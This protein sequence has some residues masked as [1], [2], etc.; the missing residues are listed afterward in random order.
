MASNNEEQLKIIKEQERLERYLNELDMYYIN[1]LRALKVL[2]EVEWSSRRLFVFNVQK[3]TYIRLY[4]HMKMKYSN[5]PTF[6]KINS[7]LVSNLRKSKVDNKDIDE[8]IKLLENDHVSL[9]DELNDNHDKNTNICRKMTNMIITTETSSKQNKNIHSCEKDDCD[10]EC[11]EGD[12]DDQDDE[13]DEGDECDEGDEGSEKESVSYKILKNGA[14]I[15]SCAI[16]C[17][18]GGPIGWAYGGK[19]GTT[20]L[21][22]GI[23]G[24][25]YRYKKK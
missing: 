15:S 7:R 23:G 6:R 20:M 1:V 16:A 13:G 24:I 21:I 17:V 14:L 9:F 25:V 10:C 4:N 22:S 8:F 12:E 19:V 2:E 18:I 5:N 11:D 3:S